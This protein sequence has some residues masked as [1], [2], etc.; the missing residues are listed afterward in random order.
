MHFDGRYFDVVLPLPKD[1]PALL[2]P[3]KITFQFILEDRS[4]NCLEKIT[5]NE[6]GQIHSWSKLEEL[7]SWSYKWFYLLTCIMC[8]TEVD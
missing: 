2:M 5:I 6:M 7:M 1:K 3:L 4:A 8:C